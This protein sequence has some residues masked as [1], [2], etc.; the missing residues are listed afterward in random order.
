MSVLPVG[1]GGANGY[2]IANSLRFRASASASLSRTPGAAG[3]RKLLSRRV[4]IKRGAQGSAQ[5][6]MSAGTA[7]ID[8]FYFDSSDRLC[9]DVLGVTRLVTTPVFRDPTGWYVDVGFDLDVANGTAASRAK[10]L[11]DG[12][13]VSAYSTDSRASIA[14][15]DTNWNNTV[16]QYIGRDNAGS[17]FDGYMA[18]PIGVDGGTPTAYSSIRDGV[19]VP[20]APSAT[21]GTTGFYLKFDDGSSATTLCYDRSGNG[22][23]W[24]PNN[25]STTAGVT[26]DWM[27]DTPTNNYATL[28]NIAMYGSNMLIQDANLTSYATS[29]AVNRGWPST[30]AAPGSGKWYAEFTFTSTL[31]D[32][33]GGCGIMLESGTSSPGELANT[34]RW[35]DAANLRQNAAGS[36][37]GTA[38]SVNDVVMVAYDAGAGKVWFGKQGTWFASGNPATDTS[39]SATGITSTGR[40]ASYHYSTNATIST[41]FGQRPFAYTPPTGFQ[42]L[43]TAN[44]PT[45]TITK[46]NKHFDVVT[47]TGTGAT[48]TKTGLQFQ[49]D[50]AWIKTRSTSGNHSLYDSVRGIYKGLFTA[51]T[52][53]EEST[54]DS[55]TAFN[56]DGYSLGA[57]ALGTYP[58]V[59]VNTTTYVDWLWK[60]GGT[61]VSNSDG[62]ITST[63]S[64]NQTAGFSIVTYTGTGANATVGHGLGVAPKLVVVKR[65]TNST[66]QGWAVWHTALAGTEYLALNNSNAKATAAGVWNS[67]APSSSVVSVGTDPWTNASGENYVAYCFAEIPGYSKIGSYIGNGS[68][69]GPFVWCGFRPKYLL[70]KRIDST[71][72]WVVFDTSRDTL[73]AMYAGLFPNL[74]NAEY[75]AVVNYDF[76]ATGFKLRIVGPGDNNTNGAT[77]IFAAFAEHPFGGSNVSPAPAR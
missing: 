11:I 8:K 66:T 4:R 56:S 60:A 63:V 58:Q 71:G 19:R 61:G 21:Y 33:N 47:R 65:R 29:T 46:P 6:I 22:N 35:A 34:V 48:Y 14:N 39:P 15:T 49:P 23:N 77:H 41:N 43:C 5:V 50:L 64:A 32:N 54:T 18:E 13:E 16:V 31:A 45:V 26:Y 44:L 42:A 1:F 37:Y 73:N 74:S 51:L 3:N 75:S 20:V 27:A 69:D 67:T 24:T 25:I 10:I 76:T 9:L 68:A 38:L 62:S 53:A 72:N 17:Y 57:N 28:N 7:S 70:V 59:N 52:V 36:S 55:F 40:F 12:T 30:I 2:Q